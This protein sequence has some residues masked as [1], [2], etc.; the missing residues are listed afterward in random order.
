M[1]RKTRMEEETI[2]KAKKET[3]RKTRRVDEGLRR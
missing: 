1:Q 2:H 3:R